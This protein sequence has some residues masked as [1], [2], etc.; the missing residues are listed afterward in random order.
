LS[1]YDQSGDVE[2]I[3]EAYY[4]AFKTNLL[5]LIFARFFIV[6]SWIFMLIILP[7]MILPELFG[8]AFLQRWMTN[9]G[10][11][12]TLAGLLTSIYVNFFF[13]NY[14]FLV[15]EGRVIV[16][17]ASFKGKK[18]IGIFPISD[19]TFEFETVRALRGG[20]I[21]FLFV[22]SK[23]N[24]KKRKKVSYPTGLSRSD[25]DAMHHIVERLS[26]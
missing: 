21:G 20:S 6:L 3:N 7:L 14:K 2:K 22:K 10:F 24:T 4:S 11:L 17:R 19:Y 26:D 23:N 8:M 16:Y 13:F 5:S 1:K 18:Q 15:G 12:V 9:N 25:A